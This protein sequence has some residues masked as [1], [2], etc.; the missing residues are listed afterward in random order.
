M[1]NFETVDYKKES[2][3]RF[4]AQ[5][6]TKYAHTEH[7]EIGLLEVN[8]SFDSQT[9][10]P[11]IFLANTGFTSRSFHNIACEEDWILSDCEFT[12][13]Y[14]SRCFSSCMQTVLILTLCFACTPESWFDFTGNSL[15]LICIS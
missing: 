1:H 10:K 6:I 13:I 5:V 8:F 14:H 9:V 7:L 2:A 15:F 3:A 11:K 4:C 12:S